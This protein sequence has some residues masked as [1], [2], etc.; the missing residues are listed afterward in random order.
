MSSTE[1]LL[2]DTSHAL[3]TSTQVQISLQPFA[4]AA[5]PCT[6]VSSKS[7]MAKECLVVSLHYLGHFAKRDTLTLVVELA[8]CIATILVE[9]RLFLW[10]CA[11]C[12]ISGADVV[13]LL[14]VDQDCAHDACELYSLSYS[15]LFCFVTPAYSEPNT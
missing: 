10:I 3:M 13:R 12:W 4:A 1:P 7:L 2:H 5:S 11:Q 14:L 8:D 9:G 15:Q 6:Y